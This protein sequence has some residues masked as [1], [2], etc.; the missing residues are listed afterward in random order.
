VNALLSRYQTDDGLARRFRGLAAA[1][2]IACVAAFAGPANAALGVDESSKYYESALSYFNKGRFNEAVIQLKNALKV[3]PNNL[4]ARV[5]IGR[6]HL[7]LSDGA[8]AE[9]ELVRA[10]NSGGDEALVLVPLGQAYLMQRKFGDLLAHIRSGGRS[11]DLEARI[12]DLRGQALLGQLEL[13]EAERAFSAS[14]RLRRGFASPMV[15]L[16][17]V[18]TKRGKWDE[19][20][21]MFARAIEADPGDVKAYHHRGELRR[22]R[23]QY[24]EAVRDY[25]EA[26]RLQPGHLPSRIGRAASLIAARFPERALPD[27]D[28]VR[29]A[30]P[31][32]P[33]AAYYESKA[34]RGIGDEERANAAIRE[35]RPEPRARL[36]T[37]LPADDVDGRKGLFRAAQLP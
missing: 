19:A 27:L 33:L 18:L 26:I 1:A 13:T 32:D 35:H 36:R 8:S 30:D 3:D 23:I 7:M 17:R 9:K 11:A 31:G 14:M 2:V 21:D 16:A 24:G 12:L 29:R 4:P 28:L 25:T 22:L 15:G 6:V 5:L 10:L 34:L 20:E 37:D